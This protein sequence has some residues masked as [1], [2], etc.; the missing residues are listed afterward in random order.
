MSWVRADT[1]PKVGYRPYG[2]TNPRRAAQLSGPS[3]IPAREFVPHWGQ[4][5][6][7]NPQVLHGM[8]QH[9]PF[10]QDSEG[11]HLSGLGEISPT[12]YTAGAAAGIATTD[13]DSLQALGAT[14][15][16][17]QQ[18][19]NG[20]AT[21]SQM[22]LALSQQAQLDAIAATQTNPTAAPAVAVGPAPPT[23]QSPPGSTLLYTAAWSLGYGDL[24]VS[25]NNVQ[26]AVQAGLGAHGMSLAGGSATANF[27]GTTN[28]MQIT[29][30]DSIGHALI[31]DAKSIL[32]ALVNAATGNN[33]TSSALVPV[34]TP[35]SPVPAG[36]LATPVPNPNPNNP[37][38]GAW[39]EAN[40][41]YL[42]GA[43][44][45]V[46]LLSNLTGKRR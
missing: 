17:V 32:D 7:F 29:V 44:A 42:F 45:G 33:L 1:Q 14:D 24:T 43:V 5:R 2:Q 12:V 27:L 26:Q 41:M 25:A 4:G 9:R 30:L 18:I 35:G 36:S 39:L 20:D 40:W 13:L 10:D 21:A 23:V 3:A 28:S 34:T 22:I 11:W 38:T 31:S 15:A 16:E 46:I 37:S 19:I 6:P 8:G